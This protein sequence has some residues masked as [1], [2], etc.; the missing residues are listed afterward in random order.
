MRSVLLDNEE[1]GLLQDYKDEAP[2]KLQRRKAEALLLLDR[3]VARGIVAE[4]VQR[5]ES[6]LAQWVRDWNEC[7]MASIVTGHADNMNRSKL[8]AEQRA[9]ATRILALSPSE[10]GLPAQFWTVPDL[11]TWLEA[12]FGVVYESDRSYHFLLKL[13]GLTFHKPEAFDKRRG[14]TE[15][16]TQRITE[17]RA[18]LVDH[19]AD[20]D[21][22]VFAA[23][24]VRLDQEAILRKA[25][26][27]EGTKPI[28]K[29]DRR[30]QSQSF[31]GFLD[32]NTGDCETY[33]LTW[34]NGETI[35]AAMQEM[36]ARHPDKKKIVV[37][38]DNAPWHKTK[39]IREQL[40]EGRTLS[41]VHLIAFPPYAPDHNPIEHVW[42]DTK[43]EISNL[44]RDTFD[45]TVDAF[46][47]HIRARQFK[48][49]I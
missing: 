43:N 44:Q 42:N 5:E 11:A 48:Y 19:L 7:R 35:L 6:T 26:C 20:P 39:L 45:Q 1:R 17:I 47:S 14:T 16:I 12:T 10:N 24:E 2:H 25:W 3:G 15:A 28:I 40:Q 9:E 36:T 33:R 37:V 32:Q 4:F 49:T 18:E 23:D 46:E 34:Q 38:W 41:H 13:A 31:I 8:T 22:L 30:K 27:K 29:V 21:T